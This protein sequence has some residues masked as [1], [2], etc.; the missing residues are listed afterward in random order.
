MSGLIHRLFLSVVFTGGLVVV[1]PFFYML[2][3]GISYR[4][5]EKIEMWNECVKNKRRNLKSKLSLFFYFL[6]LRP[7]R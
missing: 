7:T 6:S 3:L 5:L 1:M 2:F 4:L